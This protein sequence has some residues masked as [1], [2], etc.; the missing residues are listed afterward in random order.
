MQFVSF[1]KGI[2]VNG[3][4][5]YTIVD[6]FDKIRSIPNKILIAN[7]IGEKNDN[8]ELLIS[9]DEWY[10]QQKWLD[11]F[12]QIAEEFGDY[13]L[14]QIG[15]KIPE[16][17]DFPDWIVDIDSSIKSI[18]IAYHMNHQKNGIVMFNPETGEMLE[19]IGHYSYDRVKD[20]N[21]IISVCD[22]PY[23]CSFDMGILT[24]MAKK[25]EKRAQVIHSNP[26]HCRKNKKDSC[27]YIIRW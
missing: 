18:D 20:E 4:T 9:Q 26:N 14:H 21:V 2:T 3:N 27:K 7:E 24:A 17:A 25:F 1:E 13:I 10:P 16:N 8:N 11:T 15:H 23:P 6:G 12:R 19:G 22:N 5:V